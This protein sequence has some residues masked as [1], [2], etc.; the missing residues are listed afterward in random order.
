M[1]ADPNIDYPERL[2]LALLPTPLQPLD[3]LSAQFSGPR[4][5][6]KRDDL[7]DCALSGNKIRKLEFTLARALAQGCDTLI[8][9]GGVQSNHCRATAILGARLGLKV[10]LILRDEELRHEEAGDGQSTSPDGNLFL[11]Y[12]A[13]AEISIYSKAEFQI[14]QSEL[15]EH[16]SQHYAAQGRKPYL[17]PTG[18]SDGTGIWGYIRCVDELMSDFKQAEIQPAHIVHATGSGG[19]QAGLSLG[20]ALHQLDAQVLGIAVCD[21]AAYFQRKVMADISDWQSRYEMPTLPAGLSVQVNDDFIGPGYSK[22]GPDVFSTIKKVAA[23]EGLLLDPV[24]TGKAFHG[25]LT[26][27]EQGYFAEANDIVFIHT[28]GLFGLFAQRDQLS[29]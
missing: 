21:S 27:I 4:I 16:W 13:G 25:M 8:T 5:W 18:A 17:I 24:Y 29:F 1:I 19:T 10:H 23:L 7:T 22:A 2:A 14:R 26:L 9:C 11:D 3:R 28:G 20:C 12:L 15:F 6:V